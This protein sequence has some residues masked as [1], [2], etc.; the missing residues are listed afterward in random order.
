MTITP[1]FRWYDLWI[2]LFIDTNK[3]AI[4]ICPMPMFG[5]KIQLQPHPNAAGRTQGEG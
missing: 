1:F 2:G 3:R 4:Y 5:V